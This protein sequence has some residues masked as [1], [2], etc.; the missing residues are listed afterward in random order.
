MPAVGS[1]AVE[2]E[3]DQWWLWEL[4]AEGYVNPGWSHGQLT[5]WMSSPVSWKVNSCG[6][7]SSTSISPPS[8]LSVSEADC[9][10]LGCGGSVALKCVWHHRCGWCPSQ[11]MSVFCFLQIAELSYLQYLCKDTV[12]LYWI[13]SSQVK[14][15]TCLKILATQN[16]TSP[17]VIEGCWFTDINS[18]NSRAGGEFLKP[19]LSPSQDLVPVVT[20]HIGDLGTGKGSWLSL[21]LHLQ[22][23][24]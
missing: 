9:R 1:G 14:T 15:I 18:W 13:L 3:L 11:W 2:W 8:S 7:V 4:Q 16:G 12:D 5:L 6:W 20:P 19:V 22:R 21:D 23:E 24:E 10:H 17:L